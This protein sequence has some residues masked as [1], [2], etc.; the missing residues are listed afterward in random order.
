LSESKKRFFDIAQLRR[1]FRYAAPYKKKF[2]LSVVL[3]ILLAII[4]PVRPWLI[5]FTVNEYM[6]GKDHF[7]Q[8][9]VVEL[10]I[11][12]TI[13]QIG[14]ILVE[15]ALRFFF[16]FITAWLGQSVVRDLRVA[17]YKKILGLNLSQF[18]KTPIGTLTTRSINDIESINDIFADGLVPIIADLLSIVCVLAYMFSTDP[19]LTLIALIPFPIII[20]ATYY[21]KE[22][23]NKSFF[24]VRNAVA[25]LNA[26]V[27]EHLTG[28]AIVQAFSSEEREH[29]KFNA[30]NKEHRNANVKAIFAYSVFFPVVEIVLAL[31][32][33]LVVWWTSKE[34]LHL[35]ASQQGTVI[36]FILCLNLLFRPLRVIADKFNVLQM[37]II[38]SERVFK[39]L[40]NDDFIPE[41]HKEAYKPEGALKGKLEFEKVWFAYSNEHYVLKELSFS[42]NPGETIAIVGHTGSGKTTIISL[43]N[44][45]Y[46][47]QKGVIRI[48]DVNI[49]QYDL[50]NLRR[51]IGVVLQDVFLFSGS[52]MDNITL[53]NPDISREKVIE[54]AKLIDMHDFIMGLP[55]GYDFDVKERGATLSLGQRQLLSF[56]R[57]LLYNPSILI[58]DEATSSVDTESELLIQHAIDT[59][60]QGRTSII[61]AH[62]LSTIR[63]AHK[64]IVLDKGELK[65]A[66][67]HEELIA[68]KGFY[69][70]LYEMQFEKHPTAAS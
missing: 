36:S 16:T 39:V 41:S 18:D 3:A 62:R 45:L 27:Q 60:I 5:Q 68:N 58:L 64:I 1:V 26:F 40:D 67:T 51:N 52:V 23:I 69:A 53:R 20:L 63:K 65:E 7:T 49:E 24:T 61:I 37:G 2:Y 28:M 30:I 54:A 10:L 35:Q 38:A 70:Q 34:A 46:H 9:R 57:A 33:G 15:T 6:V 56:I 19:L 12:I 31:S 21:F 13:I 47:I 32:I 66:G 25:N 8:N 44:R 11:W 22:S 14:L 55:G 48:D 29:K 42:V 4:T 50:D 17:V 43:L 59:L